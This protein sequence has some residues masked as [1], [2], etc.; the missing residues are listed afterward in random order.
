[1]KGLT[2][3]SK[4]GRILFQNALG[5]GN[6]NIHPVFRYNDGTEKKLAGIWVAKY[7]M[8]NNGSNVP[9]SKPGIVSWRSITVAD[10][11]TKSKDMYTQYNSHLIRNCEWGAVAYLAQ[12]KYGRHGVQV[13]MNSSNY[14]TGASVTQSTTGNKYVVFD[15]NGG[16]WEF[17]AAGLS[18]NVANTF[19]SAN[20]KYYD[21]YTSYGDRYG[22][23][24]YET[25]TSSS[26][27]T[28]WYGDISSF[29]NSTLTFHGRGG[30]YGIGEAA[31]LFGFS[32]D[33]VVARDGVSFRTALWGAL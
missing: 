24:V 10:C 4:T 11:F 2:D 8:S 19:G 3:E 6:W 29:L 31:G 1:M 27:N 26:G 17:V 23:A 5:Q 30:F 16:A 9:Q 22:D 12:S 25:S 13:G 33:E 14:I 15:M 18:T 21:A 28:S 20:A 7:E 32:P